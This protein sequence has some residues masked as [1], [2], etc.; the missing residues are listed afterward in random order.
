MESPTLSQNLMNFGTDKHKAVSFRVGV[1]R[2]VNAAQRMCDGLGRNTIVRVGKKSGPIL[3]RFW[4]KVHEFLDNV[5]DPSYFQFQ[6]LLS[7]RL[8]RFI[9]TTF[10]IKCRSR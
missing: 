4:T 2:H 6:T 5:G 7:D 3:S 1:G 9:Q 10:A 8:P